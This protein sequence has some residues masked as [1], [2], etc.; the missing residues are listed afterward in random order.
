VL[1]DSVTKVTENKIMLVPVEYTVQ[2]SLP[3]YVNSQQASD[4]GISNV[5]YWFIMALDKWLNT[6]PS[7][8]Q[9]SF[10]NFTDP[11]VSA[12]NFGYKGGFPIFGWITQWDPWVMV[13]KD[14]TTKQPPQEAKNTVQLTPSLEGRQIDMYT[15]LTDNLQSNSPYQLVWATDII[16]NPATWLNQWKQSIA[17]R[18]PDPRF[19]PTVY[20]K[21][22]ITNLTPY[23]EGGGWPWAPSTTYYPSVK[24]RLRFIYA[25]WGQWTYLWTKQTAQD[26]G[27]NWTDRSGSSVY[28][29]GWF[30]FLGGI[31]TWF[32]NPFNQLWLMFILIVIVIVVVSIVN[33]GLWSAIAGRRKRED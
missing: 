29:G 18:L 10:D 16:K 4:I 6:V 25:L 23:T 1:N 5:N 3:A 17:D 32:S 12:L 22:G 24:I 31:G 26:W 30:D 28:H 8:W 20:F 9:D 7:D 2:F 13:A 19:T 15:N 14:G 11:H 33:P 21:I 27:Y